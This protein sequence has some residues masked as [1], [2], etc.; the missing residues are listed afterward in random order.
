MKIAIHSLNKKNTFTSRWI[1]YCKKKGYDYKLV[2]CYDNNIINKLADIDVFLWHFIHDNFMEKLVAPS[3]LKVL[4][5]N[6]IKVYPDLRS[7]WHYDDKISQKYL[8]ESIK[9]PLVP[10][11]VFYEKKLAI[12][13]ISNAEFPI[14]FKLDL[15]LVLQ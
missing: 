9:A 10:S 13:W 5:F 15:V 2:N 11:F 14:V 6:K 7:S 4:E 3:L 12:D 8:L 1:Q